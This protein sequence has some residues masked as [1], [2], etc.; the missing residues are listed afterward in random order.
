MFEETVPAGTKRLLHLH[1]DGDEVAWALEG[2]IT[3]LIGDDVS[4]GGPGTPCVLPTQRPACV[5]ELGQPNRPRSP[6]HAG[7]A[8]GYVE[9]RSC[10]AASAPPHR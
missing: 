4:V 8:G 6:L 2:E 3:F 9:E 5:E 7:P 10:I 1:R